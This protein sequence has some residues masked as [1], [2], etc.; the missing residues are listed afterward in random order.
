MIDHSGTFETVG[1]RPHEFAD[2]WSA[3]DY[4]VFRKAISALRSAVGNLIPNS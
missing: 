2:T 4:S 1:V 3:Y